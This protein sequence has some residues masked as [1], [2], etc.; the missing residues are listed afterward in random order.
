MFDWYGIASWGVV[1][2]EL[3]RLDGLG[4]KRSG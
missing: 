3:T 1:T 4:S 2:I